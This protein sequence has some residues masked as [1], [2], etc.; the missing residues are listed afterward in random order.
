[1]FAMCYVLCCLLWF[2]RYV[3]GACA[4]SALSIG[5][6]SLRE[7]G[8]AIFMDVHSVNVF[9]PLGPLLPIGAVPLEARWCCRAFDE[10]LRLQGVRVP[11][12]AVSLGVAVPLRFT[13]RHSHV[14]SID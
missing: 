2:R 11:I 5:A 6:L 9:K 12:W 13:L 4:C 3:F 8:V 14:L 7:Y 10:S 1:M